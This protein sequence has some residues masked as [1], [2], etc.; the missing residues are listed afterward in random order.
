MSN[1][2][3]VPP[4]F[5]AQATRYSK[6]LE[7]EEKDRAFVT[8]FFKEISH[9]ANYV[10]DKDGRASSPVV[11]IENSK[12]ENFFFKI[13]GFN[14]DGKSMVTHVEPCG[15]DEYLD[16]INLQKHAYNGERSEEQDTELDYLFG[17]SDFHDG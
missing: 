2:M 12:L 4:V 8:N 1:Y 11:K 13:H 3:M 16:Y 5:V 10:F 6:R 14:S 15:L 9:A 7:E 17:D